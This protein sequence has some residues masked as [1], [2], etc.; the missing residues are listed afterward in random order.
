MHFFPCGLL[1]TLII[2]AISTF[3]TSVSLYKITQCNIPEGYYLHTCHHKNLKSHLLIYNFKIEF[4]WTPRSSNNTA[5]TCSEYSD[6]YLLTIRDDTHYPLSFRNVFL[7]LYY[8]FITIRR[9]F[10]NITWRGMEYLCRCKS[11]I[12]KTHDTYVSL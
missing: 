4:W 8:F 9:K 2:E 6:I 5:K 10:W 11:A 1:I 7:F 3:E 12:K